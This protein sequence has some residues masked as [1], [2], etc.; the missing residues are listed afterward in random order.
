MAPAS[1]SIESQSPSLIVVAPSRATRPAGSTDSDVQ[2]TM[3]GLPICRATSAAC[4]VRPPTAVTMAA[5]LAK[6]GDAARGVGVKGGPPDG[7]AGG[8]AGAVADRRRSDQ[9]ALVDQHA[10]I[11]TVE[12]AQTLG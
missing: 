5:A 7:D 11:D 9:E 8:C 12:P 6:H 10:Q 4:A 3:H 1:P 2:P